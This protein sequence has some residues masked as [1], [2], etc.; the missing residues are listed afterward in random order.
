M[1]WEEFKHLTMPLAVQLGAEWDQPTWRLFYRAVEKVPIALYQSA[2]GRAAEGRSKM[3]SAAQLR[4][5]AE[6]ERQALIAANP[7]DGCLECEHQ[8]GWRPTLADPRRVERCPCFE[9]HQQRLHALGVG[10]QPLALPEPD[11]NWTEAQG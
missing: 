6:G 3:P 5:L 11:R 8:R 1:T 2:I 10:S 9:R 4:E 7:Y